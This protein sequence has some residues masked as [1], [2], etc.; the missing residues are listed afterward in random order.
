MTSSCLFLSHIWFGSSHANS[1]QLCVDVIYRYIYIYYYIFWRKQTSSLPSNVYI[2][3]LPTNNWLGHTVSKRYLVLC[4]SICVYIYILL[5][6]YT[7]IVCASFH[8]FSLYYFCL[9]FYYF[10]ILMFVLFGL[11]AFACQEGTCQCSEQFLITL[12]DFQLS[13][14]KP[15]IWTH[16]NVLIY[17]HKF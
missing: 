4:A 1:N 16:K 3:Q 14:C 13:F 17:T 7:Y 10:F 5:Y 8:K 6:V 2:P 11:A 12:L 9:R 15:I